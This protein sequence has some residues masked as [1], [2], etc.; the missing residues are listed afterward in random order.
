M[1]AKL[2]LANLKN[3]GLWEYTKYGMCKQEADA[4]IELLE[5]DIPKPPSEEFDDDGT[6]DDG[7][8][9]FRPIYY[10]RS[11]GRRIK[12]KPNFCGN[13]GQRL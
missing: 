3:Y 13:C 8:A 5:R 1:E 2:V 9:I 10:C 6:G 11:C 4:I 12:G 7:K